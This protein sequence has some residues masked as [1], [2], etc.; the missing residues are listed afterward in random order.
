MYRAKDFSVRI[1]DG[2]L[3]T[4]SK[5]YLK[6]ATVDKNHAVASVAPVIGRYLLQVV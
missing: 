4:Q 6:K 2:T 5:R 1:V 3:L